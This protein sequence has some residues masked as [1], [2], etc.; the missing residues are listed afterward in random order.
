MYKA[1]LLPIFI[2]IA[3]SIIGI[4]YKLYIKKYRNIEE[5]K[6][7]K[8]ILI[9]DNIIVLSIIMLIYEFSKIIW[10]EYIHMI[11]D[12]E[13]ISI[14]LIII[15]YIIDSIKNKKYEKFYKK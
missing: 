10:N 8:C 5:S 11:N 14:Y 6:N 2:I 12:L 4:L 1:S 13:C 9:L 15:G 3:I 7:L